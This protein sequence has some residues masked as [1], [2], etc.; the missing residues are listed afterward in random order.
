MEEVSLRARS[1]LSSELS[2]VLKAALG[3]LEASVEGN[4]AVIRNASDKP[5]FIE[6]L[7]VLYYYTVNAPDGKVIRRRG[8][9][10]VLERKELKP[11]EIL[12]VKFDVDIAGLKAV[13]VVSDEVKSYEA[14]LK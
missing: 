4:K 10:T 7:S 2:R 3:P 9:E 13:L 1:K 12:N 5:V 8:E 6:R 11:N 14:L